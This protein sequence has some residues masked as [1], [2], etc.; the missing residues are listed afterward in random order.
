VSHTPS[1][2]EFRA[3][4]AKQKPGGT[5]P[6]KIKKR[7]VFDPKSK[8]D[9]ERLKGTDE[10]IVRE[11]GK[12]TG[13]ITTQEDFERVITNI[14]AKKKMDALLEKKMENIS[15]NRKLT[16]AQRRQ[17]AELQRRIVVG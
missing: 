12:A 1:A 7:G 8:Y 9:I 14:E 3:L 15:K 17:V 10:I 4:F 6:V 16:E 13:T 2:R 11:R 5:L